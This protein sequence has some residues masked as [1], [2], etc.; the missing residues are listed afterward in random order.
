LAIT[1]IWSDSGQAQ[2][3]LV[4]RVRFERVDYAA[5]GFD[6]GMMALFLSGD[7]NASGEDEDRRR[8]GNNRGRKRKPGLYK[9]PA[10]QAA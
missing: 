4:G 3:R 2:V 6:E 7:G 5:D 10:R 1:T 8:A 9:A